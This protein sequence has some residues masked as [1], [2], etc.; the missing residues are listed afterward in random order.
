MIDA[1]IETLIALILFLGLDIPLPRM[2]C[3]EMRG[4][5]YQQEV[6]YLERT[7]FLDNC[8]TED[9][10][11][12][13]PTVTFLTPPPEIRA[14]ICDPQFA[15]PCEEALYVSWHESK[16]NPEAVNTTSGACN[17]FQTLECVGPG[18]AGLQAHM[19]EAYRKW[20]ACSGGSFQCAWY[21]WW[22]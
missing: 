9:G 4:T 8:V 5:Q 18:W 13:G 20:L 12:Q 11:L 10:D 21:N 6:W 3:D 17:L 19:A 14:I 16:W 1:T 22:P 15:W 2:N 7:W